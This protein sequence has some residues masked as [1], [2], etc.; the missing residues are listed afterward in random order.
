[1]KI[2]SESKEQTSERVRATNISMIAMG[3]THNLVAQKLNA[4]ILNVF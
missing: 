4:F 3:L 2:E 1:M